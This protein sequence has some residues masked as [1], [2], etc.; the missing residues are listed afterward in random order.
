MFISNELLCEMHCSIKGRERER[1]R[2]ISMWDVWNGEIGGEM[3]SNDFASVKGNEREERRERRKF[4]I[5]CF[6]SKF[7]CKI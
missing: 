5:N 4:P 3:C 7:I 2:S 6:S 1:E